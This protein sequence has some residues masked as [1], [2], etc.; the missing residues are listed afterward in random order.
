MPFPE[1][2]GAVN[3]YPIATLKQA[4]SADLARKFVELVTGEAGQKI[5]SADGF[6]KP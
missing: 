6:G 4:K 1:A 5:L 2:V 3:T